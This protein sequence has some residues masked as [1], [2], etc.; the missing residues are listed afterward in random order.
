MS[1]KNNLLSKNNI[2]YNN[3]VEISWKI[4]DYFNTFLLKNKSITNKINIFEKIKSLTFIKQQPF[5]IFL[6]IEILFRKLQTTNEVPLLKLNTGIKTINQYRLYG[7]YKNNKAEII[8]DISLNM[9]NK[10]YNDLHQLKT[11]I[12]VVFNYT[13]IQR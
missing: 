6:P 12:F 3:T 9:I 10:L 11:K 5:D 2:Y 1:E 4:T 7:S 13:R 8:P